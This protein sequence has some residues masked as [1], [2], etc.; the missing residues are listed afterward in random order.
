MS[1]TKVSVLVGSLRRQSASR[2]VARAI[3]SLAPASLAFDF[4]EIGDLPLYN[5][6]LEQDPPAAFTRFRNAVAATQAVLFVTPEYNR[7]VPGL[8]KNAIDVGSRPWGKSVWSSKPAGVVSTSY[9]VLGGLGAHHQLRQTAAGVNLSTMPYP[10]AYIS[11]APS[12]FNEAGELTN[13]STK[14]FLTT[15]GSAF[16]DWIAL[17][18]RLPRSS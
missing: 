4:V 10:E 18:L 7:G 13:A 15:F 3:A 1:Q 17:Q 8:L 14:E 6:D 5:E 11:N 2:K 12:L 16:A 9:G